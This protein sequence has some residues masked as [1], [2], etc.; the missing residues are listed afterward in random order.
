LI[1]P[2][3]LVKW[4]EALRE[5]KEPMFFIR[6]SDEIIQANSA[7]S[8]PEKLKEAWA[9]SISLRGRPGSSNQEPNTTATEHIVDLHWDKL[10][11]NTGQE[12]VAILEQQLHYLERRLGAALAANLPDMLIIHG[13]GEG[14]LKARVHE[15]LASYPSVSEFRNEWM[16]RYGMGATRVWFKV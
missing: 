14:T 10:T 1:R 12:A 9:S 16:P 2:A 8:T 5:N 11:L 3:Q 6:L 13:I 7:A 15:L 4:L